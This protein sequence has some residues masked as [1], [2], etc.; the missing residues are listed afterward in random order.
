MANPVLFR[1]GTLLDTREMTLRAGVHVL[2]SGGRIAEIADQVIDADGAEVFDC[3]GRVVMP[4]LIDA[5]VH[6]AAASLDLASL[7]VMPP[8]LIAASAGPILR[9][10]LMRGFTT[11]RDAG[12]ADHGLVA[13][14]ES[15]LFEGPR[16]FI[17]GRALSQTGGH[18]DFC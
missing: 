14:V 17:S 11:V 13:A 1:N 9:G 15:G 2:V 12:G 10:M 6:V 7:R 18:G 4:G 8:S 5:H 16:L 3:A